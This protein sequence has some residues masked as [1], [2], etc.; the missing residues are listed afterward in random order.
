MKRM[1]AIA[2][3]MAVV[4]ALGVLPSY[5]AAITKAREGGGGIIGGSLGIVQAGFGSVP[6]AAISQGNVGGPGIPPALQLGAFFRY[7]FTDIV[8]IQAEL[9]YADTGEYDVSSNAGSAKWSGTLLSLDASCVAKSSYFFIGGGLGYGSMENETSSGAITVSIDTSGIR[10]V[11]IFGVEIPF[12]AQLAMGGQV[13]GAFGLTGD[14]SVGGWTWDTDLGG[15]ETKVYI[16]YT[17]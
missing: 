6:V 5:A 1:M 8:G 13:K 9:S 2:A 10:L 12:T 7:L 17:F 15:F 16:G 11:T 4:M 3:M 14:A